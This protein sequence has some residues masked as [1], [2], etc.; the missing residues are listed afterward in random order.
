MQLAPDLCWCVVHVPKLP[1]GLDLSVSRSFDAIGAHF[2]L[3][4][5][6]I[7]LLVTGS[8]VRAEREKAKRKAK[9]WKIGPEIKC[10]LFPSFRRRTKFRCLHTVEMHVFHGKIEN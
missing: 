5:H 7:R 1:L 10:F 9:E 3:F 2:Y 4:V 6:E 8:D